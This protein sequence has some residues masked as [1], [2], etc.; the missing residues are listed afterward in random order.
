MSSCAAANPARISNA[1]ERILADILFLGTYKNFRAMVAERLTLKLRI[2]SWGKKEIFVTKRT[3]EMRC[4]SRY[5][6]GHRVGM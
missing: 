3:D 2:F 4:H 1:N 6:T 5:D